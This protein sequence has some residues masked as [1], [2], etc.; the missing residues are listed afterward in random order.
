[1]KAKKY[2]VGT[3]VGV[4]LAGFDKSEKRKIKSRLA[5]ET[6]QGEEVIGLELERMNL[7]ACRDY[8]FEI[9]GRKFI[10]PKHVFRNKKAALEYIDEDRFRELKKFKQEYEALVEQ[11]RK[12]LDFGLKQIGEYNHK[13]V[14]LSD[15]V[16]KRPW[17]RKNES[18]SELCKQLQQQFVHP[19]EADVDGRDEGKH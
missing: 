2:K 1:M 17:N 8:I 4:I 6:E 12:Q 16:N 5:I 19:T 10:S 3:G 13:M 11:S 9:G 7:L 18:K 14:E 15:R